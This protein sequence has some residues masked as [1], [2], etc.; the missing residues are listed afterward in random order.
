MSARRWHPSAYRPSSP[1][2]P[3]R[4]PFV[5][6]SSRSQRSASRSFSHA[7]PPRPHPT[8]SNAPLPHHY[9]RSSPLCNNVTIERF[10][11]GGLVHSSR[12]TLQPLNA[13]RRVF[14][15]H[16]WRSPQQPSSIACF[17]A[18]TVYC[19]ENFL[20]MRA[21]SCRYETATKTRGSDLVCYHARY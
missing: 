3:I 6:S 7:F 13:S 8:T 2:R 12:S 15:A 4:T 17:S 9:Q 10:L 18:C 5:R 14:V 16:C 1:A 21:S 20:I 11:K 19:R